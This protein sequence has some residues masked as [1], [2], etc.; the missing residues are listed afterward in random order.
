MK[1]IYYWAVAA[2]G[3]ASLASCSAEDDFLSA[4]G[5]GRVVLRPS[6]SGDFRSSR[7]VGGD[8]AVALAD[9]MT[10]W[11]ANAGGAVRSYKGYNTVPTDGIWLAS[12]HYKVLAWAGDSVAASRTSRW[13][14][15]QEEFTVSKGNSVQV[16]LV[17]KIVNTAVDVEFADALDEALDN[18]VLTIGH[19]APDGK[20]VFDKAETSRAYYMFPA[21]AERTLSWTLS[22]TKKDGSSYSKTG[23]IENV[24]EATLYTIKFDYT[25]D[26]T[27]SSGGGYITIEVNDTPLA[28]YES[29]V[30]IVPAPSVTG[31]GFDITKANAVDTE[32]SWTD[33][34]ILVGASGKLTSVVVSSER[35][36]D[37]GLAD[38]SYDLL[39]VS[40]NEY[41]RPILESQGVS[42]KY[43]YD[44]A[45]DAS[46]LK[47]TFAKILLDKMTS[48]KYPVTIQATDSEGRTS[49]RVVIF[50]VGPDTDAKV[51][52]NQLPDDS[53]A[54]WATSAT[55]SGT[56][57]RSDVST[58]AFK[59]RAQ[60][61]P[62]WTDAA[63]S[64]SGSRLSVGAK[65][66]AELT[67]LKPATTYEYKAIADGEDPEDIRTFTTEAAP[68]LPNS[69]FEIWG[70]GGQVSGNN[71]IIPGASKADQF[72]DCGNW[73][74]ATLNKMV[75]D[76][77]T[78]VKHGGS[79]SCLLS[80]QFVGITSA[81]GKFAA[82]NVFVG[83]YLDTEG[84]NG[85]IGFGRPWTS[86][87]KAVRLWVKYVPAPVSSTSNSVPDPAFTKGVNDQGAIYAA[88]FNGTETVESW[89]APCVVRTKTSKFFDKSAPNVIAYTEHYFY[90]ATDGEGMIQVELPFE[91]FN[92][93]VKATH[94]TVVCSASRYGDYFAGG[95]GS[96]M[97][98]DDIELVY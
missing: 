78:S 88:V 55:I 76:K 13:F 60:D 86:R 62:D 66:T 22:G 96:K 87:P 95:N 41:I 61:E 33:Q 83:E 37:L 31:V 85:V 93:N 81:L 75:T 69:D 89:T 25:S 54:V 67:G 59:Y 70:V 68:Q 46:S 79:Y 5:E 27:I 20:L 84:T 15:G 98:V 53:P 29:D 91:Y 64:I 57:M 1:K 73:G 97:W 44:S 8:D 77:D 43:V 56:I 28:E 21:A 92:S 34:S 12:D 52:T 39:S 9:G 10:I 74:S 48:G 40:F 6:L 17:C 26:P 35:F 16:N 65:F 30:T 72:W 23:T 50:R 80:S 71:V 32:G 36:P 47:L 82:G 45:M 63:A 3:L 51:V 19:D 90:E 58:V 38:T 94:I 14:R 11:I 2:I 24:A 7:A 42:Y 49:Q 18:Y 4:D